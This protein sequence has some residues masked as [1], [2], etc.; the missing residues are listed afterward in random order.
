MASQNLLL[1][2]II[3]AKDAALPVVRRLGRG[4]DTALSAPR[5][6]LA[7]LS[8]GFFSLKGAIAGAA[9]SLGLL[10]GV[11]VAADVEVL[12][13]RV[14]SATGSVEEYEKAWAQIRRLGDSS[15]IPLTTTQVANAFIR[16]KNLGLEPGRRAIISYG[17]TA[18]AM[19]KDL[20]DF[21]EAVADAVT[22]EFE[23]LKEFGIKTRQE[24]DKVK[25]TFQGVSTAV[26]KDA[27]AIEAY[28]QSIGNVQFAGQLEAQATTFRGV[29]TNLMK[30][31]RKGVNDLMSGGL[32]D[33]LKAGLQDVQLLIEYAVKS[34]KA[35]EWGDR[36]GEA[37]LS[38]GSHVQTAARIFDGLVGGVRLAVNGL[39]AAFNATAGLVAGFLS[40][41]TSAVAETLD[42]LGAD[43]WAEEARKVSESVAQVSKAYLTALREDGKDIQAA[44]GHLRQAMKQPETGLKSLMDQAREWKKAAR[45]NISAPADEAAKDLDKVARAAEQAGI[46]LDDI[47]HKRIKV[48]V[49][50]NGVQAF[51]DTSAGIAPVLEGV[52]EAAED[53]GKALDW[54]SESVEKSIDAWEKDILASAKARV[55]RDKDT[56]ARQR[57]AMEAREDAEAKKA[58]AEAQAEENKQI[59]TFINL[60]A[61]VRQNYAKLSEAALELFDARLRDVKTI[62]D[63]WTVLSDREFNRVKARYDDLHASVDNL[64]A[65]IRA[66]TATQAEM[67]IAAG[68]GTL[69]VKELGQERLDGLRAALADAK[70]R[71]EALRASAVDALASAL[72]ASD[73]NGNAREIEAIRYTRLRAELQEQLAAAQA[74]HDAEAEAALRRAIALREQE[75]QRNLQRIAEQQV[76]EQGA[77]PAATGAGTPQGPADVPGTVRGPA[78]LTGPGAVTSRPDT[79]LPARI[80]PADI[81]QVGQH[82]ADVLM[83]V[84]RLMERVSTAPAVVQLDGIE[85]GRVVRDELDRIA[86]RSR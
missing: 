30:F 2:L 55:E 11:D 42:F 40:G 53:A 14:R 48:S 51:A 21:V 67:T 43:Q 68:Q 23:R 13:T 46:S 37:V 8:R 16:L 66:G 29:W 83:P 41:V 64:T 71:T 6:G 32:F 75:H 50:A 10:K 33:S 12:Q 72:E 63:W 31:M 9:A 65:R 45:E 22:L 39:S 35:K 73:A 77:G 19:G 74:A 82:I 57:A 26:A 47:K 76:A 24:G 5:R 86:E 49:D 59:S 18:K 52:K 20:D 84:A 80:E 36:I 25:F 62:K 58:V 56:A 81:E 15:Q 79:L 1:S 78:P 54:T 44:F 28:L 7:A 3:R 61:I 38:I 17:N 4:M 60:T 69:A 34:G 70:A 27:A 85:L